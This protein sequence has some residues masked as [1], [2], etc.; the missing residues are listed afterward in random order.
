MSRALRISLVALFVLALI[1]TLFPPVEWRTLGK[2]GRYGGYYAHEQPI[3]TQDFL[4]LPS[5]RDIYIGWGWDNEARRSVPNYE[6]HVRTFLVGELAM[7]Y[8]V[9]LVLS[10][11][12]FA[13]LS[14]RALTKTI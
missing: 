5:Q 1:V 8:M 14:R 2:P 11:L 9:I 4:F 7:R 10:G 12:L 6:G 13:V 3:R